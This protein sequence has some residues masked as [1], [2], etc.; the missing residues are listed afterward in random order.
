MTNAI[1]K[2]LSYPSSSRFSPK[3]S[4]RSNIAL[5]FTLRSVIHFELILPEY[6]KSMSRFIFFFSFC[7]WTFSC[8][9]AIENTIFVPLYFLGF[10]VKD[11]LYLSECIS[12]L[13][14][15]LICLFH[16]HHIVLI[17]VTV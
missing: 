8:S 5:H 13:S 11:R 6:V 7:M 14:I 17:I 12:G 1:S 9:N 2:L 10:F 15:L 3:L 4:Y 16:Q